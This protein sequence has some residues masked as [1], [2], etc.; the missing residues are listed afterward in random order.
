MSSPVPDRLRILH[1]IPYFNPAW[2]YGGS[3]RVASELAAHL[4]A[5]GHEVTVYTTDALDA[6]R[7]LPPGEHLVDG[8]R[9]YRFPNLSNALAWDRLFI[10]LTF[11][12][13]LARRMRRFDVAHLHEYRSLQNAFA[14]PALRRCRLPYVVMP[15]GGLPAELRRTG[16]KRIYDALYGHRL[17][18]GAARLHAL[19]G[20]ERDQYLALGLPGERIAVIPNGVDVSA[21]EVEA[22][23]PAF[24]HRHHIPEGRP[25]VGYLGRLSHIKGLDFLVDAFAD[26]LR[27][28]PDAILV[29]A[30]PDD[31]AQAA[32]QTQI[33]RLGIAGAVRFTGYIGDVETKAA[34]YRA[35]GVY[36]LPSRYENQPTTMLEAL[37]NRTPGILTDRCGM[38][39]IM[40]DASVARVVSFGKRAE[41]AATIIDLLDHPQ[42]AGAQAERG[43]DYVVEHFNWDT[44]TGHWIDLY[45]ACVAESR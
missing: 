33:D 44:L 21:F 23:V 12:W 38:A 10:P 3:V 29:L 28:K 24:K 19:T 34:A 1:I 8:I 22:D 20:M 27:Q 45:R 40:R 32:L 11:G 15:H 36:V 43:R 35:F 9:V 14:L 4:A 17:L 41:L 30:G 37:L 6:R 39:G 7:R 13:G 42:A 2:A 18:E 25:I 5:H 26:V 16:I 31:G